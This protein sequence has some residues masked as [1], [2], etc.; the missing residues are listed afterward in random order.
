MKNRKR[1]DSI[2]SDT[3]S[4]LDGESSAA[5]SLN[6]KRQVSKYSNMAHGP[7]AQVVKNQKNL[8]NVIENINGAFGIKGKVKVEGF[9]TE[10]KEVMGEKSS[11]DTGAKDGDF[12][13]NKDLAKCDRR[14]QFMDKKFS[15]LQESLT[16]YI[17]E[18]ELQE[19]LPI[20][21]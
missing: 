6:L 1:H 18:G 2:I 20:Q 4:I 12:L 16:Q 11:L 3:N 21:D 10:S 14:M 19:G 15:Y 17:E 8:V 9:D 13:F 5:K 7:R